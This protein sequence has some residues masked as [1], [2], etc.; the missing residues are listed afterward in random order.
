[1]NSQ[2]RMQMQIHKN[3]ILKEY[4]NIIIVLQVYEKRE[5]LTCSPCKSIKI[6]FHGSI[7]LLQVLLINGISG[8]GRILLQAT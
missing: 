7:D 8:L 2:R 3:K 5:N 1:M 4:T 6:K